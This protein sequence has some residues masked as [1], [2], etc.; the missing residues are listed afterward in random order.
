[1]SEAP[2]GAPRATSKRRRSSGLRVSSSSA[3]DQLVDEVAGLYVDVLTERRELDSCRQRAAQIAGKLTG[4][5]F[6]FS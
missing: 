1:M 2:R 6:T 3:T 5:R 4:C